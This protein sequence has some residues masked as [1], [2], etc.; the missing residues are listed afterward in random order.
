M[1]NEETNQVV[2]ELFDQ[3]D[4]DQIVARIDEEVARLEQEAQGVQNEFAARLA[5]ITEQQQ[6]YLRARDQVT[7]EQVG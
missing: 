1:Y 3:P 2:S 6:R 5:N 7:G 4:K